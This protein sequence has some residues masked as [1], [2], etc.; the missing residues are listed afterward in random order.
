M[1]IKYHD[2]N[3]TLFLGINKDKYGDGHFSPSK[4]D[5]NPKQGI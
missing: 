1:E 5:E 4:K 3:K 2:G